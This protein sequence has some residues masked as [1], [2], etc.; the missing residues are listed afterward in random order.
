MQYCEFCKVKIRTN[1]KCCPL[2]QGALVGELN[3]II[4][5]FPIVK[6]NKSDKQII[7][8]K[9]IGFFVIV[10]VIIS[11]VINYIATPK[12]WWAGFVTIGGILGW[13]MVLVAIMKRR[14]LYK[15]L[16]W[17]LVIVNITLFVWDIC[18]GFEGWSIDFFFPLI[19]IAILL[20]M[21]IIIVI[22]KAESPDYMIYLLGICVLGILP[23]I[24]L[25][26]GIV[27]IALPSLICFC[28]CTVLLFALII[29][30]NKAVINELKKKFHI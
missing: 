17:Q 24:F 7:A 11:N 1:N 3:K 21:L 28:I 20:T 4:E 6:E 15:N 30:Q 12:Y 10:S 23:G 16:L 18:K 14:N 19:N 22:Q 9:I 2:C 29:F 8:L 26:T 27:N 5:P 13:I 25:V